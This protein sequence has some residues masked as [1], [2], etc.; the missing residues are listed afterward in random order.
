MRY[1]RKVSENVDMDISVVPE[2]SPTLGVAV[3]RDR[4]S[5]INRSLTKRRPAS[6]RKSLLLDSKEGEMMG[7]ERVE[8]ASNKNVRKKKSAS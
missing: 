6:F 8:L 2:T 1:N 4:L 3:G 5:A 7:T